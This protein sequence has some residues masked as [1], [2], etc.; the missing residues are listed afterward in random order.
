MRRQAASIWI[1]A[2]AAGVLAGCGKNNDNPA[3]PVPGSPV[4]LTINQATRPSGPSGSTVILEGREFGATQGSG[5][6]LFSDGAGASVSAVI[7][8]PSDWSNDFVVT[9]VPSGAATGP[10][11]IQT[12]GGVSDSL[13]FTIT[14]NAAFSPST[15]LWTATT[16]L[17]T[18]LSGHGAV[19]AQFSAMGDTGLV[20][21]LGGADDSKAP[22][23]DVLYAT[24]QADGQLG[25]W[26]PTTALPESIA[27]H[28]ATV[29]TPFNSLVRGKG[30]LYT[31]GGAKDA[32]GRPT[33]VVYRATLNADGSV[34]EW[35]SVS[36][37]PKPLHS[38]G[39]AVFHGSLYVAGGATQGNQPVV[40]TYRAR[41]DTLGAPG[42][43]EALTT[44]PTGRSY[45]GFI[46][47]GG[48]LYALGGETAAVTP[49]DSTNTATK[50]GEILY[51]KIDL[52]TGLLGSWLS[53]PSS[54]TK[55]VSKH[56]VVM[57]G[58][59]LL[60]T[61][62]IY[63]GAKNGSTEETY[64]QLNSDGT[65]SSFNGATGSHTI[66]SAGGRNLYNHAAL[67]YTDA[68][69]FAH[70]LVVG[71]DDLNNPG[72]KRAETWFY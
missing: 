63:N 6:V 39:A 40:E 19:F 5:Q 10:V 37:L 61:A 38:L 48:Y 56:T 26:V 65:V 15:I 23:N 8:G 69:G 47:F 68:R 20:Y 60:A 58:G 34:A 54:M 3:A 7:A 55:D 50:L 36:A 12:A 29:A 52:R 4:L 46:S 27:F 42:A 22:R 70:V 57:S 72:H 1:L 51:A 24:V 59:Y 31:L 2:L 64:A 16:P 13:T 30:H 32:T 35:T 67:S 33:A 53:N 45:H 66:V 49:D 44:L 71:G 14:Q 43:W 18:G 17:P 41:I 21:V 28:A 11:W 9:T 62:G 25:A